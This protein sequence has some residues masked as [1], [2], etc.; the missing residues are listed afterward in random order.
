MSNVELNFRIWLDE[1]GIPLIS[2]K[3]FKIV[4]L[5]KSP[6]DDKFIIKP[7]ES[8]NASV[9]GLNLGVLY[10]CNGNNCTIRDE[11]K[12]K[13]NSYCFYLY[14]RGFSINHQDP[15]KPIQL[16]KENSYYVKEIQ[17][18]NNTNIVTLNWEVIEYEEEKGVFGKTFDKVMGGNKKYY[19]GDYKLTETITDDGHLKTYPQTHLNY[20]DPEGNDYILLLLFNS[21]SI[22]VSVEYERY[23]RKKVSVMDIL[24]NIASLSSTALNLMGMLM[25]FYMLKIITIIK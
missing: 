21:I 1:D 5:S 8:F 15:E 4:D 13:E 25:D 2:Y 9:N 14:Y 20:T 22:P 11:D 12:I 10:R 7:L 16:I 23:T 24:A 19:G 18:L 6:N 3:N 17:F